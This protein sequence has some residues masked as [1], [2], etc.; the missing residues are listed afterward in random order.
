M[1]I[2]IYNE[3]KVTLTSNLKCELHLDRHNSQERSFNVGL[4]SSSI[5]S[6]LI[7]KCQQHIIFKIYID[8]LGLGDYD[9]NKKWFITEIS[10]N[11]E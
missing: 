11:V 5:R 3:F 6:V 4:S 10:T 2:S 8:P 9:T 7:E 1:I